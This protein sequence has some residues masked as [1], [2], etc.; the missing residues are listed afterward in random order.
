MESRDHTGD[1]GPLGATQRQR[2][3]VFGESDFASVNFETGEEAVRYF[4]Q[5]GQNSALKFVHLKRDLS[6]VETHFRPYDLVGVPSNE[7][8]SEY[9]TLSADGLVQVNS[10]LQP[11]VFIP[12]HEW[13]QHSTIF[14][15]VRRGVGM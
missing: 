13:M 1:A 14:N 8:G 12:L 15:L 10:G 2:N 9:Y 3:D 6:K 5:N 4:A 7:L 11:S